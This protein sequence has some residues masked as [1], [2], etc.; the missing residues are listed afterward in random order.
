M[1]LI[2]YTKSGMFVLHDSSKLALNG[3]LFINYCDVCWSVCCLRPFL[4]FFLV[5]NLN[6]GKKFWNLFHLQPMRDQKVTFSEDEILNHV[7]SLS[8]DIYLVLYGFQEAVL[9]EK[10]KCLLLQTG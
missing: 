9:D 4:F 1:Q 8:F 6:S 2:N 3:K 7:D 5:L 10:D